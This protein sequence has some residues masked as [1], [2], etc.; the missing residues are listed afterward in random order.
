MLSAEAKALLFV[1]TKLAGCELTA[2]RVLRVVVA[3]LGMAIATQGD[4]VLDSA[5]GGRG[6]RLDVV[7]F[8][9]HAAAAVADAATP[10]AG[11]KEGLDLLATKLRPALTARHGCRHALSCYMLHQSQRHTDDFPL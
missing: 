1:P 4:C 7:N 10:M 6:G 5:A 11:D 8:N 2:L 3:D 9:L